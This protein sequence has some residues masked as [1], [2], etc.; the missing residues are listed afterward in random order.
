MQSV[1]F[2][3]G[4]TVA[5]CASGY[6]REVRFFR[7]SD[8]ALLRRFSTK[9]PVGALRDVGDPILAERLHVGASGRADATVEAAVS[10]FLDWAPPAARASQLMAANSLLN[11]NN[12]GF[13]LITDHEPPSS[14]GLLFGFECG[15]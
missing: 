10:P 7:A 6:S 14:L 2:R 5:A 12:P 1:S 13:Q 15:R 3:A 8:G 9:K 11:I 4:G